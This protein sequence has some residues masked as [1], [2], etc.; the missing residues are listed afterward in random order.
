MLSLR[1]SLCIFVL[2]FSC[3]TNEQN[4]IES[5]R[6]GDVKDMTEKDVDPKD[7]LADSAPDADKGS[8]IRNEEGR[9]WIR[10]NGE[11]EI[12]LLLGSLYSDPGV[13]AEDGYGIGISA[14]VKVEGMVDVNMEGKYHLTY[15]LNSRDGS[16]II[17][18]VERWVFINSPIR[19]LLYQASAGLNS[20]VQYIVSGDS[21]RDNSF[22]RSIPYY[23]AQFRKINVELV[24]NAHSGQK[25]KYWENNEVSPTVNEAIAATTGTGKNTILELS[26]G[27]NDW[28][29]ENTKAS[30]KPILQRGIDTYLNAKPD[31]HIYLVPPVPSG[32]PS[33]EKIFREIYQELAD[34][35]Q[36]PL[37][38][39]A[40]PLEKRVDEKGRDFYIDGLHPNSRGSRI[41]IDYLF[42]Q[43]MTDFTLEKARTIYDDK[44]SDDE[45]WRTE[46][47]AP[48]R[49][50]YVKTG[51][52][53]SNNAFTATDFIPVEYGGTYFF[54]WRGNR[55]SLVYYDE[56]KKPIII[57][58]EDASRDKPRFMAF[59]DS[60]LHEPFQIYFSIHEEKA[61]FIRLDLHWDMG[62]DP[63]DGSSVSLKRVSQDYP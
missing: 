57:H 61:K 47:L 4:P 14:Q 15:T 55:T 21:T 46:Y 23:A 6:P 36:L 40:P 39:S 10:L 63:F 54:K 30:L 62:N 2:L 13:I 5:G 24:D 25:A 58:Y 20:D 12:Y 31:A 9:E 11:N 44:P 28:V 49:Y 52:Y 37:V 27:H 17:D 8:D 22:S 29:R 34:E 45:L 60:D 42:S 32:T 56:N 53:N 18:S 16:K 35:N 1:V 26:L 41:L 38:D 48:G 7:F 43:I 59:S 51:E 3:S 33:S 50:I 19:H